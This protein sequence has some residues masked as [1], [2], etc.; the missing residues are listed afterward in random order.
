LV[1]KPFSDRGVG[2]HVVGSP[3]RGTFS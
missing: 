2:P 3:R 1:L